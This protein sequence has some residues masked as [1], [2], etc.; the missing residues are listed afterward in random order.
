MSKNRAETG[1]ESR[2]YKV[3]QMEPFDNPDHTSRCE[4]DDRT[5]EALCPDESEG[6]TFRH[7]TFDERD[8]AEGIVDAAKKRAAL[9]EREAYEKG[10]A[11]GEKDGLEMGTKKLDKILDRVH[12][13]L[14]DMVSYRQEFIKLYEK[15]ILHLI[16]RVA[17]K[18]LRERVKIDNTIVRK[19]ILEAF[20][21]AADRSEV[22]IRI[23]PEDVE[24]L[25][26]IRPEFFDRIEDLK[27]ITI[28]ADPS[29]SPGGCFM[30][31][32]FGHVDARLEGQLDK[33]ARAVEHALEEESVELVNR[34]PERGSPI[35]SGA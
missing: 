14:K 8:K 11:Q 3:F 16:C 10:Y 20:S 2:S 15:D 7:M 9:I 22:T 25:K 23:N 21:L 34:E 28:E 24:Y 12:G 31:T 32:L 19:T 17:E 30:E 33:I 18:V 6:T 27:S 35:P 4:T 1:S 29:I 13:T 5:F 26:E